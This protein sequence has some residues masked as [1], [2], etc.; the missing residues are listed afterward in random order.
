MRRLHV[1]CAI[2]FSHSTSPSHKNLYTIHL[3]TKVQWRELA[4]THI[5][6]SNKMFHLT[7][8]VVAQRTTATSCATLARHNLQGDQNHY[9]HKKRSV[10][11]LILLRHGQSQW[12]AGT[13]TPSRSEDNNSEQ[14]NDGQARFTG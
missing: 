13:T 1:C 14:S 9:H 12:N 7:R 4:R 3:S 10:S 6:K 2:L 11:T 8:K 5:E